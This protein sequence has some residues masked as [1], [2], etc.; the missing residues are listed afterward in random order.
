[1]WQ[2]KEFNLPDE[3]TQIALL[4]VTDEVLTERGFRR[5][6]VSNWAK[7]G[8]ECLHNLNYW[9]NGTYLG[10]GAGAWSCVGG[11]RWENV[12]DVSEYQARLAAGLSIVAQTEELRGWD[13]VAETAILHFRL[14]G[15]VRWDSLCSRVEP[16][17]RE[18]LRLRLLEL[19]E[20]GLV[21]FD[22]GL[23]RPTQRGL[24]LL[25]QVGVRLLSDS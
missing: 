16:E 11:R 6:E 19:A 2:R 4:E 5:Y 12:P 17:Y 8:H 15:G 13:K 20:D 23:V 3:D 9:H 14:V 24:L 21:E 25:N 10:L 7:P 18:P 1:M 22:D